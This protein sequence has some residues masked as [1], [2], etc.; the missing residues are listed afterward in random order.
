MKRHTRNL[1]AFFVLVCLCVPLANCLAQEEDSSYVSVDSTMATGDNEPFAPPVEK[2]SEDTE[3]Y[4]EIG[5][6]MKSVRPDSVRTL[7]ND[8]GFYYMSF[9]DS[10]L[11]A[12]QEA[13]KQKE[14]PSQ[15]Q[16]SIPFWVRLLR[17]PGMKYLVWLLAII[18]VGYI[19][20]KLFLQRGGMFLA[21]KSLVSHVAV[22]D[23][24]QKS[25]LDGMLEK[26]VREGNFR[27]AL[28]YQFLKTLFMLGQKG[29]LKLS[30]EKTDY[31]YMQE[32]LGRPYATTFAKLSS[33]YEYVW[34]GGFEINRD[35]FRALQQQH[36]EFLK[37]I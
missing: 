33:Q 32:L 15:A 35:Q 9:L 22:D 30:N 27:H 13:R 14:E 10:M 17:S 34:F 25:D 23:T 37:T 21:N 4:V 2:S 29:I 24:I 12:S 7:K 11:R 8:A 6:V 31:Q 19:L 3:S 28:R 26:S 36:A 16:S 5:A 20:Y 1:L 18:T